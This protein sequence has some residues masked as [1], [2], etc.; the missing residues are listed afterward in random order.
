MSWGMPLLYVGPAFGLPGHRKSV[1][2]LCVCLD[3]AMEV[4]TAGRHLD[5]RSV[6]I[7]PD[8]AH[9]LDF[10]SRKIAGLYVDPESSFP[11]SI[12]SEMNSAGGGVYVDHR[13]Q[14]AIIDA[15]GDENPLFE[16]R[17]SRVA[18]ALGISALVDGVRD[19]RIG[20]MVDA[21]LAEPCRPHHV[22]SMAKQVSLSESRM[23]HA[24]RDLTG[25]P[26]RRFRLWARMGSALR[27]LG[28]GANLTR[29]AHEAGF[30]SSA[31]FSSAYRTMF[32]VKPSAVVRA[33]P[34]LAGFRRP[35]LS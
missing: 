29:A 35:T 20:R 17:R 11:R 14:E 18:D 30:S 12:I 5:C 9:L 2:F 33:N 1:G 31:H 4:R 16:R 22:L 3:G 25:V 23:R 10:R 19:P 7:E 32:G 15:L 8:V 6:Y 27:L 28:D 13:R 21:I 26:L 34:A 24:F